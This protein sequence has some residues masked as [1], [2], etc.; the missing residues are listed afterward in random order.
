MIEHNFC[1]QCSWRRYKT[2]IQK[3]KEL[4]MSLYLLLSCPFE[5][6]HSVLFHTTK[7]CRKRM[8]SLNYLKRL[9]VNGLQLW[10]NTIPFINRIFTLRPKKSAMFNLPNPPFHCHAFGRKHFLSSIVSERQYKMRIQQMHR[11]LMSRDLP[12]SS[13]FLHSMLRGFYVPL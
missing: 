5:F 12:L 9:K 7:N 2:R 13:S 8:Q 1:I 11:V 10:N 4:V 3:N 6:D